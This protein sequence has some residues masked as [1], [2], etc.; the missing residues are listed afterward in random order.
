MTWH[1]QTVERRVAGTF[2]PNAQNE[3]V[4]WALF[5]GDREVLAFGC[6]DSGCPCSSDPPSAADAERI[7]D[8]LNR[9][10]TP[11]DS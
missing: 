5:E 2:Y 7:L 4:V 6:V 3:S 10:A 1:W 9:A 8:A 11:A